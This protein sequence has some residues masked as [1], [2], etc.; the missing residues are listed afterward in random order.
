[1]SFRAS[2]CEL[3]ST[4]KAGLGRLIAAV[5][6]DP[7][8][9]GALRLLIVTKYGLGKYEEGEELKQTLI[10]IQA[11]T[12]IPDLKEQAYFV[13]DR[14][15]VDGVEVGATECF[16]KRASRTTTACSSPSATTAIS[17]KR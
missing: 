7:K 13:F 5:R 10:A 4:A 14:F 8:H 2:A 15:T 17:G 12:D 9:Y 1:M 3:L 16:K 11:A 6:L